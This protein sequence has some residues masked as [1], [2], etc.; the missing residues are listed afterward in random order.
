MDEESMLTTVDNPYNPWTEFEEWNEWDQAH[1]YYTLAYQA[2]VTFTSDELSEPD[3]SRAIEQ[4]IDDVVA[5]NGGLYKKLP[6]PPTQ[7]PVVPLV[8]Q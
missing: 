3:Q 6:C 5:Y 4:G 7:P 8:D 2:R 1:G